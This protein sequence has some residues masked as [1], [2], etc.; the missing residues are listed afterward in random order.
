ML[1]NDQ[2]MQNIR[3]AIDER[4]GLDAELLNR[5]SDFLHTGK[6]DEAVRNAF[7]LLEERLRS[8]VNKD[9]MTGTQLANHA[10]NSTTGPLAKVLGNNEAEREGLRELYSGAF[11]LFRNPT[12]HGVVGYDL[13]EGKSIIGLVNLLLKMISKAGEM[14]SQALFCKLG[15]NP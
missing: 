1:L 5:C 8:A 11:K 13:V 10:F 15:H 9:G 7:I 14:I 2:E 12:A 4:S 3:Q 6:Y